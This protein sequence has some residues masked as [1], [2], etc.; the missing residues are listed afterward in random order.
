MIIEFVGPP[1]AGKS[2]LKKMATALTYLTGKSIS[3]N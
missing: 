2:E 1:G 3:Q